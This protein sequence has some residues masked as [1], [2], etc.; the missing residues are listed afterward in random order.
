MVSGLAPD[1]I[2]LV[3]STRNFD[4]IKRDLKLEYGTLAIVDALQIAVEYAAA[5]GAKKIFEETI[6]QAAKYEQ[7]TVMIS[8]MLNDKVEKKE[9]RYELADYD[10]SKEN[11][12]E[13]F[14]LGFTCRTLGTTG[15]RMVTPVLYYVN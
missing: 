13:L 12:T 15:F 11:R 6:G 2:L 5:S 9:E 14:G 10:K 3:N 1:G 8:A 7:S 4:E